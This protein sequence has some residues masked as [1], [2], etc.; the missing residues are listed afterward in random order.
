MLFQW[1]HI[2]E[3][4][5]VAQEITAPLSNKADRSKGN[6]TLKSWTVFF[7]TFHFFFS[8]SSFVISS[9][10]PPQNRTGQLRKFSL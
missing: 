9:G 3:Q 6:F 5:G 10:L 8:P 7:A 4:T 1:P 2:K